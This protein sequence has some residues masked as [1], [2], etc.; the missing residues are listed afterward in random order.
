M[1]HIY[2]YIYIYRLFVVQA[3]RQGQRARK[4]AEQHNAS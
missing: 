2:I 4:A 3:E 1:I